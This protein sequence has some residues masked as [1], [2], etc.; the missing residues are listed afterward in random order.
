[1]LRPSALRLAQIADPAEKASQLGLILGV[2]AFASI[3]ATPI[4]GHVSDHSRA[5]IGRRKLWMIVGVAG[6]G[7]GLLVMAAASSILVFGLVLII[8]MIFRPQ[9]IL[10]NKRRAA[11]FA[12]RRKEAVV[13]E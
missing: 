5:R 2:G 1:M 6:G 9:G 7:I 11:E 3:I 10:P 13:G 8:M 12:D 4:W